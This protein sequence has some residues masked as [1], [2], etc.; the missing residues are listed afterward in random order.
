M[1]REQEIVAALAALGVVRGGV[2]LVHASYRALGGAL[3]GP[4]AVID[5]LLASVG[6]GTLVMPSM[7]D[8]DDEQVFEPAHTPCLGMGVIADRFWR[9]AGV[10][11][12]DSP[13]SFAALGPHAAAITAPHPPQDP[14]GPGTPVARVHALDGQVL[15]LGVDHDANTT[16][17]LAEAL[18][19]VPYRSAK[20]CTVRVAG[21]VQRVDYAEID[22]C[23][24][25]FNQAGAWLAARG[26]EQRGYAGGALSRLMRS[27]DVVATVVQELASDR[28]RF[29]CAPSAGCDEC[30]LARSFAPTRPY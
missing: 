23:C 21:V 25:G 9:R 28:M 5:A 27:R 1:V 7:P 12:S 22:H 8:G 11:R 24:R 6:T 2:L 10:L 30:D 29:L 20:H 4:D 17:H 18:A 16:I 15:L 3:G 14:H 19:N 13:H 26:L